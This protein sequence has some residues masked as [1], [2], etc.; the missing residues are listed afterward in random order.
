VFLVT[1]VEGDQVTL[2]GNHP[3]AGN[4]LVFELEIVEI[5]RA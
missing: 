5:A 4:A 2:D 1:D 3:L